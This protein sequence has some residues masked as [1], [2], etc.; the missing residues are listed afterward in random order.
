MSW[1]THQLEDWRGNT[2]HLIQ[3]L[4]ASLELLQRRMATVQERSNLLH[5]QSDA[6]AG[7]MQR[8]LEKLSLQVEIADK[9]R[10]AVSLDQRYNDSVAAQVD[11]LMAHQN[12]YTDMLNSYRD[13]LHALRAQLRAHMRDSRYYF[14]LSAPASARPGPVRSSSSKSRRASRSPYAAPKPSPSAGQLATRCGAPQ[15]AAAVHRH[16]RRPWKGCRFASHHCWRRDQGLAHLDIARC[17]AH[18][19]VLSAA[20]QRCLPGSGS[21]AQ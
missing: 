14:Q 2:H 8:Q 6:R 4:T 17:P 10:E 19:S 7:T 16:C 5:H 9:D 15:S 1:R 3:A 20:C 21:P 18:P 12:S 13:E 11:V